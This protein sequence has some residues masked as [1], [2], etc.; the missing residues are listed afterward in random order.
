LQSSLGE[1]YNNM[2]WGTTMD[3]VHQP[4]PGRQFK[5]ALLASPHYH[6]YFL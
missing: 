5:K 3:T 4:Y 2:I 1:V 6:S